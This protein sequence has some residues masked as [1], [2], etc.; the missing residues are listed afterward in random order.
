MDNS[1]SGAKHKEDLFQPVRKY[2]RRMTWLLC[3]D[4]LAVILLGVTL[5]FLV[6]LWLDKLFFLTLPG[7]EWLAGAYAV[8]T[9]IGLAAGLFSR[10]GL[11]EAAQ[12]LDIA[13]GVRERLSSALELQMAYGSG[14]SPDW[15]AAESAVWRDAD[16]QLSR[17]ERT[18]WLQWRPPHR[19]RGLVLAVAAL[20][21]SGFAPRMDLL[22]RKAEEEKRIEEARVVKTRVARVERVVRKIAR[23]S[24]E[25]DLEDVSRI[26]DHVDKQL[27]E[28]QNR[29]PSRREAIKKIARLEKDIEQEMQKN[30]GALKAIARLE[31][32][33][34]TRKMAEQ[35]KKG[36]LQGAQ[37]EADK[38]REEIE[39]GR[40]STEE[41]EEV[42]KA[43]NEA[44]EALQ[45]NPEQSGKNEISETGQS[46]QMASSTGE[47]GSES[48]REDSRAG[49]RTLTE[50]GR[51]QQQMGAV[52]Q[53]SMSSGQMQEI[54][55]QLEQ[56]KSGQE[57][58]QGQQ[59]RA[60]QVA[61]SGNPGSQGQ[62]GENDGMPQVGEDGSTNLE[63]RGGPGRSWHEETLS[64]A[65]YV[66]LYSS[67][68]TELTPENVRAR[69]S[70][71]Q[72]QIEGSMNVRSSPRQEELT[73]P[74]SD[75]LPS[76]REAAEDAL[77][78]EEVPLKYRP[79][80][81][82]YFDSVD[83]VVQPED[84]E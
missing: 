21:L 23:E 10:P 16:R 35:L 5:F 20:A 65:E 33:S 59:I 81:R 74:Y 73:T 48:G 40:L 58:G 15:K 2:Q 30:D 38:L 46:G 60:R 57:G 8:A 18:N 70:V 1:T 4:R 43:L 66:R 52:S 13:A 54:M 17:L 22:G 41:M 31:Q 77:G 3:L 24:D 83:S 28:M 82:K 6:W 51:M 12:R 84:G 45:G 29:P 55:E 27:K 72:G 39:S 56:F 19:W 25:Q 47:P 75:T 79:M 32:N 62:G 80:V 11:L 42:G 9:L 34:K 44:N 67:R 61:Q 64:P 50:L 53:G 14:P 71:G 76:F 63:Q 68:R 7:P 49:E 26:A 78:R 37:A 36:N 69:S